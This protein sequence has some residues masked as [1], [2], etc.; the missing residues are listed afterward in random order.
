MQETNSGQNVGNTGDTGASKRK[1][2]LSVIDNECEDTLELTVA[3][4][5]LSGIKSALKG[6]E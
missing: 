6:G 1:T 4:T 2:L 3:K 5:L